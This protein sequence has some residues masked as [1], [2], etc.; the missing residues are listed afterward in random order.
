MQRNVYAITDI[1]GAKWNTKEGQQLMGRSF[2]LP[3][4]KT[5]QRFT[6]EKWKRPVDMEP[7]SLQE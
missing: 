5:V 6:L 3:I 7:G 2:P 1:A 4:T